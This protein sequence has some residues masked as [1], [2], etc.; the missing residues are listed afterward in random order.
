MGMYLLRSAVVP[1]DLAYHL[2]GASH[3]MLPSPPRMRS[4]KGRNSSYSRIGIASAKRP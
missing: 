1:D 4:T 3:N 2:V